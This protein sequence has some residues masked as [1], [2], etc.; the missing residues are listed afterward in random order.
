[1]LSIDLNCDMGE[2][3]DLWKY[4]IEK[5]FELLKSVSS[6][7]I[8]C[9]YHAGD[10]TT[11]KIL[12]EE[13]IKQNVA[14]GAHPSFPDKQNFGRTNMQLSRERISEIVHEQIN[15]L[16]NIIKAHNKKLHHVKPHGALYNMAAKDRNIADAICEAIKNFDDEIILYGLS[17]SQLIAAGKKADLKTCSEVFADRTYQDDGTL[18]PRTEPN[19][20]I[21][22]ADRAC[23]Q[24]LRMIKKGTV[25]SSSKKEINIKAE[26]ICIHG[27]AEHAVEFA[28]KINRLMKEN[29]IEVCSL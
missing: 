16:N 14:V 7:N 19:A 21:D 4:N 26:T 3:T 8:A 10:A 23:S 9:G 20:L 22:D 12:I 15:I 24:V 29:N 17:G 18:T 6:I 25:I 1:M 27:D 28:K 2:S 13:A 11:M 5:D